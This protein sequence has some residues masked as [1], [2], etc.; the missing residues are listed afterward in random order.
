M[1]TYVKWDQV[2]KGCEGNSFHAIHKS[3][4]NSQRE[5]GQVYGLENVYAKY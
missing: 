1:L 5:K 3:P 4:I 2:Y